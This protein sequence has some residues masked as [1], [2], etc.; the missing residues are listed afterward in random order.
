MEGAVMRDQRD[1][2]L[3]WWGAMMPHMKKPPQFRDFTGIQPA[4]GD[5]LAACIAAWDRID[6]ALMANRKRA[7]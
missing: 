2:S 3:V 4:R 5:D 7:A 1:K 6:R